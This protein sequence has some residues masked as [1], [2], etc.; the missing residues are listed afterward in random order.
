MISRVS[1]WTPDPG[2]GPGEEGEELLLPHH[3][4]LVGLEPLLALDRHEGH[5]L[6][7]NQGLEAFSLDRPEVNEQVRS[8]SGVMKP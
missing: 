1:H 8:D 7:L 5:L 3:L 2:P 6:A 4:D